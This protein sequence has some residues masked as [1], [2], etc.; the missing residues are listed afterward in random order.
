M[1]FPIEQYRNTVTAYRNLEEGSRRD[2][3]EGGNGWT[4][5]SPMSV[6]GANIMSEHNLVR[7]GL[8]PLILS[9]NNDLILK[10]VRATTQ[11]GS[12]GGQ[13]ERTH[14]EVQLTGSPIPPSVQLAVF[15]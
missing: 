7:R 11:G 9:G 4:I 15:P 3:G 10:Q 12:L 1:N 13:A 14:R 8:I 5:C 2:S 6:D